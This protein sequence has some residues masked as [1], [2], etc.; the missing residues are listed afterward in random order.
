[1]IAPA[2]SNERF[3]HL[4]GPVQRLLRMMQA[5]NFGG[6]SF[7]VRAGLPDA[8]EPWATRRTVKLVGGENGP[9]P[10]TASADFELRKE[11][12][13][14]LDQLAQLGDGACVTI[15]VKHGLPFIIEI[16]QDHQAA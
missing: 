5:V 16:E 13:A 15:E 9:R 14:L 7:H 3:S 4:P 8:D 1:M 2:E 6:I 10:E 12:L 11:H